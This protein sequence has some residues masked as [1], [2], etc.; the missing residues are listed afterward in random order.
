MFV[1]AACAG[2]AEDADLDGSASGI[3]CDDTDPTV[4]PGAPEA[5]DGKDNDCDG[6]VDISAQYRWFDE[7]EPND[8]SW[9]TCT[10]GPAQWLGE[11]APT[12]MASFID[13]HIDV[14][15]PEDY[16]RGDRDCLGFTLVEDATLH[17]RIAWEEPD[18]DL[19][20][21]VW[22]EHDGERAIFIGSQAASPWMDGGSSDGAMA[23]G[24]PIHLWIAPYEGV[25][26]PYRVTLWTSRQEGAAGDEET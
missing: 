26:T 22:S 8:A 25:A 11:L 14:I 12:G 7:R 2:C 13:G 18:T 9:E 5:W 15:V 16:D 17:L 3:D 21:A 4:Y 20:F 10:T 19:D 6:V 1:V 24:V 23:A